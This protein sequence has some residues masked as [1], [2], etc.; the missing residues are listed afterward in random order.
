MERQKWEAKEEECEG[1]SP[2]EL[3][4]TSTWKGVFG[5]TKG[6]GDALSSCPPQR[7][8]SHISFGD[9]APSF[10]FLGGVWFDMINF[11]KPF[12]RSVFN[13]VL[14]IKSNR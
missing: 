11:Q 1:K 4:E 2:K 6:V 13:I 10:P 14:K 5:S 9:G 12:K 8:L 3:K 7:P